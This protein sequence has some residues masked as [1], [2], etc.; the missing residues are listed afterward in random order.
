MPNISTIDELKKQEEYTDML[1]DILFM[2]YDNNQPKAHVRTY[3]C[4]QNV[5]DSEKIKGMLEKMGCELTENTEDADIIIFNTC[6]VREHAE[7]RVGGAV[8]ATDV[9]LV[10]LLFVGQLPEVRHAL[11]GERQTAP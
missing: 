5:A 6:A 7:D 4:Q 11:L 3:G 1:K 2:R 10:P 9:I 8:A